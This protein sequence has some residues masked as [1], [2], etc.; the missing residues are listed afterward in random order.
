[1][2]KKLKNNII[3]LN[4]SK[5]DLDV[6]SEYLDS[7]NFRDFGFGHMELDDG[8][9]LIISCNELAKN[10]Q[11]FAKFLQKQGLGQVEINKIMENR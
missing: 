11:D 2:P 7:D 1:M 4:L 5:K 8:A 10:R 9:S 3:E 6:L